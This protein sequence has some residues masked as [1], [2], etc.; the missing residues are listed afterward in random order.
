MAGAKPR[1]ASG[2]KS[3][4]RKQFL[5]TVIFSR[6]LILIL[7]VVINH[8]QIIEMQNLNVMFELALSDIGNN[9]NNNS[10]FIQLAI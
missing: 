1:L 7:K 2:L 5:R 8:L 9:K 10:E 3:E 4:Q 6:L